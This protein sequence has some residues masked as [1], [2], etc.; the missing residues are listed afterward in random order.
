[1]II[2]ALFITRTHKDSQL[3]NGFSYIA[4]ATNEG[5]SID[6]GMII[7][8]WCIR[9]CL[10]FKGQQN[11]TSPA[12]WFF[13]YTV[14]NGGLTKPTLKLRRGWVITSY[15]YT[16]VSLRNHA[17]ITRLGQLISVSIRCPWCPRF[18]REIRVYQ[19]IMWWHP[20]CMMT[21][22]NGNIFRVTGHLCGE[23]TCP[24]WIPRTKAS[25]AELWC[26][27]WSASK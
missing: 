21:S 24:R 9:W 19:D 8:C 23:F 3:Y 13:I 18:H 14:I 11:I 16:W 7:Y 27:L 26:F 4:K 5:F 12:M 17:P 20:N 2:T 10:G 22:S 1:M 6:F 25:D 15:W